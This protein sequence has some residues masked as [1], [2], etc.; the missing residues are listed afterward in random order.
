VSKRTVATLMKENGLRPPRGRRRAPMTTDSRHAHARTFLT[1]IL[2]SP[3]LTRSGWPT[4]VTS[5]PMR[6]GST[7]LR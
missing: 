1:A 7:L 5:R 3:S 6:A 2:R 4:S